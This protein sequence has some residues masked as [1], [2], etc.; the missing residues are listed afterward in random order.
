MPIQ[1]PVYAEAEKAVFR[2][3][4]E[5]MA[6]VR[7]E[8]ASAFLQG[9]ANALV[10]V[11]SPFLEAI[12]NACVVHL[13]T[14]VADPVLREKLRPDYRA[15]CKRL[16]LSD[17]FYAAIQRPNVELVTEKIARGERAGV[18]T[19]DGR[20]HELDVLVLATGFAVDRFMRPME[21]IGRGGTTLEDVWRDGPV[22]YLAVSIPD[23]PN[24]FMLNGPNGPVGNFSLIDVAE[25]QLAYVM[26]LVEQVRRGACREVSASWEALKRFD[27]ER[28][29]AA[30]TTIWSS[31]CKSW[32]LDRNGVPMAWP[33]TFDRFIDEM[34][35]PRLADFDMR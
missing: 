29:E 34:R 12:H 23:F 26:Q 33:W 35:A 32:Y 20:L 4:P 7:A 24:F 8:V 15:A 6:Q 28:I 10:D 25:L 18:R 5:T 17:G 22:A 19:A 3:Q 2:A 14:S 31:G 11:R 1:N 9:F 27:A 30:K 21:V 13:E 16:V